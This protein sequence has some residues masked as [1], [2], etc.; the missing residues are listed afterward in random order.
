MTMNNGF[1]IQSVHALPKPYS[2]KEIPKNAAAKTSFK[3]VLQQQIVK[4]AALKISKHANDRMDKRGIEINS[5][6]WETINRKVAEAK[7]KGVTDSLVI[8]DDATL[9]VSAKNNTV[10]TV[11]DRQ[12]AKS[13]IF[14]NINGTIVID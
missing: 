4:P 2:K 10:I 13:Q 3:D 8:T 11:M 12:E 6:Q 7:Q 1:P 14:T 9:V 5:A